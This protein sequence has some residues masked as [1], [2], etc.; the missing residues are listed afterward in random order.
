[1]VY[2]LK[3]SFLRT[4]FDNVYNNVIWKKKLCVLAMY[5]LN[6]QQ[7]NAYICSP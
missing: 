4:L 5:A 3:Q 6:L 1:M 7:V 2:N